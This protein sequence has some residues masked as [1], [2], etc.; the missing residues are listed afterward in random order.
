MAATSATAAPRPGARSSSSGSR[1]RRAKPVV[2]GSATAA[3]SSS[4]RGRG[5]ERRGGCAVRLPPSVDLP[6]ARDIDALQA[7][8][9]ATRGLLRAT[10]PEE[11]V[12]VAIDL[13]QQLGGRTV[14]ATAA[15][16][17]AL[18]VDLS[19][20][21]GDP[22]VPTADPVS[23]ARMRLEHV[24][25]AFI[26]DARSVV[27]ALR[28]TR[29]LEDEART[30]LLTGLRNRRGGDEWVVEHRPTGAVAIVDLDHFK[31]LNDTAGH[32]EGD[33]VL[34]EFSRVLRHHLG[35][36][37]VGVR[38][39]GEEFVVASLDRSANDLVELLVAVRTTW[40]R[41]RPHPVTFSA[42][43]AGI[44]ADGFDA[45]VG[46]ADVALYRA[47]DGG[48]DRMEVARD[49]HADR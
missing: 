31:H 46:A 44:G 5:P 25:P 23:V 33:R 12:G 19:F 39:G 29:Y 3:T 7:A 11:V 43:V 10:T 9:V 24:L 4:S 42:G 20:G 14:P 49:E 27:H 1:W 22:L 17:E 36:H 28:R 13:V 40:E 30:D 38:W 48:R 15:G 21:I 18:P 8:Q 32:A 34:R 45:A 35:R 2:A 16:A 47:K 6:V 37:E 26:E 41:V